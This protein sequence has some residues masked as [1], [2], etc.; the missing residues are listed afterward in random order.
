VPAEGLEKPVS[1]FKRVDLP[2]PFL[3]VIRYLPGLL[4]FKEILSKIFPDI[5]L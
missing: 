4:K 1:I 2:E 5:L 3:P